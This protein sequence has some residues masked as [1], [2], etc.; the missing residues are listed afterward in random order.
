MNKIKTVF[1][2]LRRLINQRPVV[3]YGLVA[4]GVVVFAGLIFGIYQLLAPADAKIELPT[5]TKKVP[6]T[7]ESPLTGVKLDDETLTKRP[8]TAVMIEN[9][10]DARPQSGIKDA[11]I[12]FEA[13]A[14]GGI[15]RLIA[16]YQE[17]RPQLVGP[18]R[19]L[20]PYYI[21]WVAAFDP[22]ISHVGGSK[23]ALAQLRNGGYKDLDQYSHGD[24]Y[25][26]TPDRAAPHNVYTSFDRLDALS[27]SLGFTSSH[28]TSLPRGDAK[29]PETP[30]VAAMNINFSSAAYNTSYTYNPETKLYA[31]SIGGEPHL[32]R[33]AGQIAPRVVIAIKVP[34]SHYFDDGPRQ[35]LTTSGSGEAVVFQNGTATPAT[36]RKTDAKSQLSFT[37]ADGTAIPLARGQTW[38]AAIPLGGAGSVSW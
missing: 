31:R 21:D 15:T 9:S 33:E 3:G 20:R 29:P 22:A 2:R 26:R 18:V 23:D 35:T 12:V 6:K 8:V 36:W 17:S 38:I 25:W 10:I 19:S 13:V 27:Q 14:E 37:A 16:L 34:T 5:I 28:F 1:A 11:G 24:T 30:A 4:A 32:D 7:Y